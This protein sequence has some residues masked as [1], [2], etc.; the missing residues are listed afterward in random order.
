MVPLQGSAANE[1]APLSDVRD[2]DGHFYVGF[3]LQ[4]AEHGGKRLDAV[5]T[6]IQSDLRVPV[7][8]VIVC[9]DR[10]RFRDAVQ[11]EISLDARPIAIAHHRH[12]AKL[13]LWM[14]PHLECL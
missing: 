10:D 5:L 7:L 2:A 13:D 4:R 11:R 14:L 6:L 12:R 3:D 8:A 9:L 1:I